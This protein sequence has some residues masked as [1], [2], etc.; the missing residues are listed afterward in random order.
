MIRIDP[1]QNGYFPGCSHT[2]PM[3]RSLVLHNS[4][5][6]C[7]LYIISISVC[8][9]SIHSWRTVAGERDIA[10]D[11]T[12]QVSRSLRAPV[13][14]KTPDSHS[15]R[16]PHVSNPTRLF[17][18]LF[19]TFGLCLFGFYAQFHLR[20][21]IHGKIVCFLTIKISNVPPKPFLP[22]PKLEKYQT[23]V[24]NIQTK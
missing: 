13:N 11:E 23:I 18:L 7:T 19:L 10:R 4:F 6:C 12:C 9:C 1:R 21:P 24:N 5:F 15:E 16:V 3:S 17:C 2:Q 14:G 22:F 8:S 20:F